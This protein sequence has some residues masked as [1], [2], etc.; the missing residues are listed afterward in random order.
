MSKS[1][2]AQIVA[3]D[4]RIDHHEITVAALRDERRELRRQLR[5]EGLTW[6]AI[7]AISNVSLATIQKDL[8]DPAQRERHNEAKRNGRRKAQ[9]EA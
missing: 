2:A 6:A 5:A 3:L 7:G 4:K 8:H 1:A 9:V